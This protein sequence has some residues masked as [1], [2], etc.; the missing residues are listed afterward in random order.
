MET[1]KG[2]RQELTQL[3][4]KKRLKQF[5]A[6]AKSWHTGD[7]KEINNPTIADLVAEHVLTILKSSSVACSCWS[8][9]GAYKYKR[10]EFKKETQK[11]VDEYYYMDWGVLE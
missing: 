4:Y 6:G 11:L 10:Y 3:K 7:G 1:N 9:S 2:R 5:T 8:C